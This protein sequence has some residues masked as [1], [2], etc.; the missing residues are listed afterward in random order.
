MANKYQSLIVEKIRDYLNANKTVLGIPKIAIDELSTQRDSISMGIESGEGSIERIA[1]CTGTAYAGVLRISFVY[2]VMQSVSG[3]DD[4][5]YT[6]LLDNLYNFLRMHYKSVSINNAFI[7]SVSQ[8]QGAVLSQVY[9]G[10]VKDYKTMVN[11]TYER[12]N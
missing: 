3:N 5:T 6:T 2:R 11:V 4:L 7:D 10:G 9:Q 1:D 12:S 8:N